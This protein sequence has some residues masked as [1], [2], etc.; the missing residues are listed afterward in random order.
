MSLFKDRS[1]MDDARR[2][3]LCT[4][5]YCCVLFCTVMYCSVLLCTVVY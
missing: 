3:M 2:L 4:V 1:V 5:V